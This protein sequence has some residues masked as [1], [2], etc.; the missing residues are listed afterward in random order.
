MFQDY[1]LAYTSRNA[2]KKGSSSAFAYVRQNR[3]CQHILSWLQLLTT[4]S[5]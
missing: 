5:F 4:I 3:H 1:R 2:D